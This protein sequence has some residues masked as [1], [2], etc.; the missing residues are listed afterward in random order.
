[1]STNANLNP[2]EKRQFGLEAILVVLDFLARLFTAI[3]KDE[4]KD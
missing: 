3:F 4:K 2:D 1:M